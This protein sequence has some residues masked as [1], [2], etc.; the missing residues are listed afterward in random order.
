MS[1]LWN[2]LAYLLAELIEKHA[3][4]INFD[5]LA[6][7]HIENDDTIECKNTSDSVDKESVA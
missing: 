1:D 7:F 5:D 4:E 2:G 6:S 3:N